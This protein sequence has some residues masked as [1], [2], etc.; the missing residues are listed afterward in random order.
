[1]NTPK[2]E[3]ATIGIKK[4]VAKIV[5]DTS[6][7]IWD[8]EVLK[9]A[10]IKSVPDEIKVFYKNINI[11]IDNIGDLLAYYHYRFN[12]LF[13][14]MNEKSK[15]NGHFNTGQSKEMIDLIKEI[16][17][18]ADMSEIIGHPIKLVKYTKEIE[19]AKSFLNYSGG[20]RMPKDYKEIKLYKYD[21]IFW[22]SEGD[23]LVDVQNIEEITY[24]Y[25]KEQIQKCRERISNDEYSAAITNSRTLLE[26]VIEEIYERITGEKIEGDKENFIRNWNKLSRKLNLH[27]E[28]VPDTSLKEILSGLTSIM[29]G[30][31]A[32]RNKM[33]ESHSSGGRYKASRHHAILAV[34]CA[35]TITDFLFDTYEYQIEKGLIIPPKRD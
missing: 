16:D 31:S 1:M 13:D 3:A 9:N 23:Q 32:V 29:N 25:A 10:L 17:N 19:Y 22:V 12:D 8:D 26:S 27:P 18:L 24:E 5:E 4:L 2:K 15:V 7:V 14:F 28:K 35:M 20:S 34:N 33:S 6:E 11:G 30:L 21:K